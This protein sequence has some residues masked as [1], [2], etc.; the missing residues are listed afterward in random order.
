M[1]LLGGTP[2]SQALVTMSPFIVWL[3]TGLVL[4]LVAFAGIKGGSKAGR[5]DA[6]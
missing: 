3:L 6:D 2:V 5:R 1:A 4:G